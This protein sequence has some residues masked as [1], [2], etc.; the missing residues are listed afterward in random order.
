MA[1]LLLVAAIKHTL[2]SSL[3]AAGGGQAGRGQDRGHSQP[4]PRT[5][6]SGCSCSQPETA[7]SHVLSAAISSSSSSQPHG[8]CAEG[9]P[10][11]GSSSKSAAGAGNT[12]GDINVN[13][14]IREQKDGKQ[15]SEASLENAVRLAPQNV[16]GLGIICYGDGG[17]GLRA[18]TD[19][20]VLGLSQAR[21]NPAAK[22][23]SKRSEGTNPPG[24][25]REAEGQ[26]RS[27]AA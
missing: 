12:A 1:H 10:G 17:A 3:V 9:L 22:S 2:K 11:R 14:K 21:P 4:G 7:S 23:E 25:R 6:R 13:E 24:W 15:P 27:E 26:G 20:D 19:P 16:P 18:L 8:R 5:G